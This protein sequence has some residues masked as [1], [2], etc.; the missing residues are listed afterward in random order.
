MSLGWTIVIVFVL[1]VGLPLAW[2]KSEFQPRRWL[3]ILLGTLALTVCSFLALKHGQ[4]ERLNYNAWYGA[5][6]VELIDATI[7]EIE[8]GRTRLL[9]SKLKKLR[10][11]FYPSYE[12]RG[13]YDALVRDFVKQLKES[14]SA[15]E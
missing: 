12:N 4:L 5:A 14:S 8:R 1:V 6:S 15:V 11:E 13:Q 7:T 10:E 2:L 3:R 9:V